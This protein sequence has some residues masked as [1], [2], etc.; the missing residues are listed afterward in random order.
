VNI[1]FLTHRLPYAP[2]RG[3]RARAYHL[4][5][6]MSG[7]ADVHLVSLVH[8]RD[9]AAQQHLLS[10]AV[11]TLHVAP[12]TPIRNLIRAAARLPTAMPTTYSLLYA[13]AVGRLVAEVA[14]RRNIDLVFCYCTGMGWALELPH[15]RDRPVVLDMVDVDSAKWA[16]LAS[17]SRPPRS[18]I[19]A[20]EA[21]R[22][23]PIER[24]LAL[25]SRLTLVV[26][27]QEAVT[28]RGF[29]PDAR[30]Q[31]L[32][33]GVDLERLR[34]RGDTLRDP[35]AIV[36]CGV[37]NYAPNV[38]G[39]RW[40]AREVLPLVREAHPGVTFTIVGS[41]PVEEVRR[42]VGLPGVEVTGAVPDV[43]PFLWRASVS[44]APLFTARGVQNKVLEAV[45]AGVPAVVTPRV[46]AGLPGSLAGSYRVAQDPA[47]FAE[48]VTGLLNRAPGETI[49]TETT[50]SELS[51]DRR[52]A[53]LQS[54]LKGASVKD[55]EDP[56]RR[57]GPATTG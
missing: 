15:L 17:R 55:V 8:S 7:W 12:V 5:R 42:L 18:W 25:S 21:R 23:R 38:E 50:L 39:V 13:P 16:D 56:T 32:G 52:L 36:F 4:L 53:P 48:A 35:A 10:E 31:V 11:R 28:L 2:N 51:W 19:F 54:W 44:V 47:G 49:V 24:H 37:M 3:D 14:A 22:L 27:E 45:A 30:I 34:P 1:L 33:N 29:A 9:E 40:F 43:R 46:A 57:L 26:T 6:A 41:D 20:R